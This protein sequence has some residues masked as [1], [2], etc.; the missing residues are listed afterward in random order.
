LL[1]LSW[2][3]ATGDPRLDRSSRWG[4][5]R[6]ISGSWSRSQD[7]QTCFRTAP[8]RRN[9]VR[10]PLSQWHPH[11]SGPFFSVGRSLTAG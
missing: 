6:T 9:H 8:S 11:N 5:R 10:R 4:S 3:T 2:S 1:P 7:F